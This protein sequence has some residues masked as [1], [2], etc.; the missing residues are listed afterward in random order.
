MAI[1]TW[2]LV[3]L[4]YPPWNIPLKLQSGM[5]L[6]WLGNAQSSEI[7]SRMKTKRKCRW[8]CERHPFFSSSV[9]V[10]RWLITPSLM[11]HY[12]PLLF[13]YPR[14]FGCLLMS[15]VIVTH[16]CGHGGEGLTCHFA[17][18]RFLSVHH[19]VSC[20]QTIRRGG[21]KV[22]GGVTIRHVLL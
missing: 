22:K 18:K 13:I 19:Y 10:V 7:K 1:N 9:C 8:E 11:L 12:Y 5:V 15:S 4:N 6:R 16:I 3:C 21:F 17:G 20:E 2:I 14:C